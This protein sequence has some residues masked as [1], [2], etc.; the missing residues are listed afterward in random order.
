MKLNMGRVFSS[1]LLLLAS[2]SSLAQAQPTKVN[3][4]TQSK[5]ADFS[6]FAFTKPARSGATLPGSCSVSELFYKTGGLAGANLFGCT[7]TNV[8]T[9]LGDVTTADQITDFI[10][11]RSGSDVRTLLLDQSCIPTAPCVAG[12]GSKSVSFS[13]GASATLTG[14]NAGLGTAYLYITVDGALNVGYTAPAGD[15]ITCS[16]TCTAIPGISAFPARSIPLYTWAITWDGAGGTWD[17]TG[18]N[19][20]AFL[21]TKTVL[22]GTGIQIA[23][24]GGEATISVNSSVVATLVAVP[25]T[26]SASCATGSWAVENAFFYICTATDTWRRSAIAAW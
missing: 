3:L 17:P 15:G 14:V 11:E 10:A 2:W 26:S 4:A 24:F 7:A 18:V 23:E 16:T 6:Q 21:S 1:G 12:F 20:R 25:A 8:W 13:Q 19:R 9:L 22:P 5:Q